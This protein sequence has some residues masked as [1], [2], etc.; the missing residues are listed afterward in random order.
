MPAV[1]V[2]LCLVVAL[3]PTGAQAPQLHFPGGSP[4]E[5]LDHLQLPEAMQALAVSPDGKRAALAVSGS[6]KGRA[7][8]IRVHGIDG[9]EVV[10]RVSDLGTTVLGVDK[11]A[12]V[13]HGP[14]SIQGDHCCEV[15]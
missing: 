3:P 5:I 9:S 2:A 10:V 11:R 13:F 7:S 8:E 12:D 6:G 1:V 15:V 14:G 4:P